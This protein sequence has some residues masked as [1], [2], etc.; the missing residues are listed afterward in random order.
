MIPWPL[1]HNLRFPVRT[2]VGVT[3]R[4][5]SPTILVAVLAGCATAPPVE[6]E[7]PPVYQPDRFEPVP[8]YQYLPSPTSAAEREVLARL[9]QELTYLQ[10]LAREAQAQRSPT[11]RTPFRYDLLMRDLDAIRH[12]IRQH[13]Q[14]PGTEPRA[15]EPLRGNYRS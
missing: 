4:W 12:G 10:R 5:L 9:E 2:K 13:L 3:R 7:P 15:F 11:P 8:N 1:T 6:P 14:G